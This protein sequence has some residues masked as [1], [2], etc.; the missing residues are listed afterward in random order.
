MSWNRVGHSSEKTESATKECEYCISR[1][2]KQNTTFFACFP[3]IPT[4]HRSMNLMQNVEMHLNVFSSNETDYIEITT[5]YELEPSMCARKTSYTK[6]SQHGSDTSRF[7]GLNNELFHSNHEQ[8]FYEPKNELQILQQ[9]VSYVIKK[10]I[11]SNNE[12]VLRK[13]NHHSLFSIMKFY[14]QFHTIYVRGRLNI[15]YFS[16]YTAASSFY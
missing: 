5:T 7:A 12:M 16:M 2:V 14:F 9:V 1:F 6:K 15:R 13:L 8:H 4:Q 3:I 10:L 11:A